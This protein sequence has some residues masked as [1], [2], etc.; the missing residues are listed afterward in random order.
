MPKKRAELAQWNPGMNAVAPYM[1]FDTEKQEHLALITMTLM[2]YK[3]MREHP[4]RDLWALIQNSTMADLQ[5]FGFS[6]KEINQVFTEF[7][8]LSEIAENTSYWPK[9]FF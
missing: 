1:H 6:E 9:G 8:K 5:S 7:A 4:S 2:L 3:A